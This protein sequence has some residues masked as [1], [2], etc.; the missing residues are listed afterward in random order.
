MVASPA[1]ANLYT[2][3]FH[4]ICSHDEVIKWKHFPRY[5]PFVRGIHRS[6]VTQIFDVFFDLRLNKRLSKQWWGW[7]LETRSHLLLRHCKDKNGIWSTAPCLVIP[8]PNIDLLQMLMKTHSVTKPLRQILVFTVY[9]RQTRH[10]LYH[11]FFSDATMWQWSEG[12]FTNM[13][14]L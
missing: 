1:C 10:N 7:W 11:L 3:S 12:P 5:W 6:P 4:I 13:E 14:W 8:S 9:K 2:D